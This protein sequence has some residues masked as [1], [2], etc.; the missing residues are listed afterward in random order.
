MTH[1]IIAD[2]RFLS[3]GFFIMI[4]SSSSSSGSGSSSSSSKER[5][6]YGLD[7]NAANNG[8]EVVVLSVM[9]HA[10][11]T[12][13]R[14]VCCS[15]LLFYIVHLLEHGHKHHRRE[16]SRSVPD[17]CQSKRLGGSQLHRLWL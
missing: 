9:D 16:D 17:A 14:R 8:V 15:W 3:K 12:R 1:I 4:V 13:L 2:L 6:R 5:R 7:A 11:R 10:M